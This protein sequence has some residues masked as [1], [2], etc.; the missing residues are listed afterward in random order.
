RNIEEKIYQI[1]DYL[2]CMSNENINYIA[3]HNDVP[4]EKFFI[5]E[6]WYSN[7]DFKELEEEEITKI[8]NKYHLQGKFVLTFGGNV[9]PANELEFLIRLAE[10]VEQG[11]VKD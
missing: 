5:L 8:R 4:K 1:S 10:K 3:S 9:S 7:I 2:G 11:G 6:N